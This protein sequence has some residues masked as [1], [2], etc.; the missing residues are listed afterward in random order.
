MN[1]VAAGQ[2]HT[3]SQLAHAPEVGTLWRNGAMVF[4]CYINGELVERWRRMELAECMAAAL[5]A[6]GTIGAQR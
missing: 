4:Y 1:N 2:Q 5:N 6:G 3:A